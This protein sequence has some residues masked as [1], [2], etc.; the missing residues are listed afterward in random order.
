[1]LEIIEYAKDQYEFPALIV[2]GC[3]DAIHVGHRELLKKAKL[4]AKINGLD[5]GVM[6]FKDGKSGKLLYSFEERVK[7]LEEFNVKFV[8]A[9]DFNDDF[10]K[11]AALD[12]LSEIE[13]KINVKAYMSGK[14][15][16]FGAGAKGKASTLKNYAEDDENGVWYMNV[17]D[18]DLEGEK[19][20][21][22]LI[23]SC[24]DNG[25][26]EKAAKLLGREYSLSG[27]VVKGAGRGSSIVGYPTVN[28]IN[29]DW[30]YPVKFGVYSV[31]CEVDG[32]V[33][34]GVANFGDCPTFEDNR[35]ALETYLEGYEGDLYGKVLTV[36]FISFIREIEKFSSAEELSAQ[37][38]A[39]I[40]STSETA[41]EV[42]EVAV[43]EVVATEEANQETAVEEV[44]EETV[45]EVVA[46]E[47]TAVCDDCDNVQDEEKTEGGETAND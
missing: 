33:Y 15:F 21:T 8:L 16:R 13:D 2:L 24:L 45:E 41:E 34:N 25:D 5:L 22:T 10:K 35:V 42:T 29:P 17:K 12:F 38:A 19:I 46:T 39:D 30:K 36:N 9:I 40:Q 6:M 27:E 11:I 7:M 47:E 3:F 4:Q 44:V 18:V 1:M 37:V 20:S 43:E 14:D 31:S 26:V 32:T 23:K 28:I